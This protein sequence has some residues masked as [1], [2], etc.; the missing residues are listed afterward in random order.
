MTRISR[1]LQP[2]EVQISNIVFMIKLQPGGA[3]S[4]RCLGVLK[5]RDNG[6]NPA[7]VNQNRMQSSAMQEKAT[8][9]IPGE[10]RLK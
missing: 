3:W 9:S 2:V 4:R 7:F 6:S 5:C 1:L 10:R 8:V